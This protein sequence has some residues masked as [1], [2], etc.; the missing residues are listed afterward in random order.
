MDITL[1]GHACVR[2]D[3][4]GSRLVIDP[5]AFSATD[6]LDDATAVLVTHDHVDHVV[7]DE[8]RAALVGRAELEVWAPEAVVGAVVGDDDA[9]ASRVHTVSPGDHLDVAGFAVDVVGDK[10]AVIHPDVPQ[11]ANVGYLVDG[12][13]LHPGDAFTVPDAA[14]EVLLVPVAAPWLKTAEAID[15]VRAVGARRAVPI[16]DAILADAGRTL[17]DGLLGE[18]GP[19]IGDTQYTRVQPGETISAG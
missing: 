15:Y 6:A 9:V 1:L 14:V 11:I 5:G 17:V 10:H 16:H 2:L 19:G 18:R 12:V 7:P 13:V 4:N 3:K 8:L